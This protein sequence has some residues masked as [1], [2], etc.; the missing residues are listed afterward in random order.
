MDKL[1]E[2]TNGSTGADIAAI[3]NAAAMSAIKEHILHPVKTNSNK[4]RK[5]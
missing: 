5:E 1:V 3:I 2:I 4:W